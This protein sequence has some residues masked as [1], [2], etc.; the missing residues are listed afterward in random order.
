MKWDDTYVNSYNQI[1]EVKLR[2]KKFL[3]HFNGIHD[4]DVY[5]GGGS[6]TLLTYFPFEDY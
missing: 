2:I 3:A 6:R 1:E 4:F 5:K